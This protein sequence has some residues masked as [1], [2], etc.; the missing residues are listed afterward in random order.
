MSGKLPHF[1][2]AAPGIT[3]QGCLPR[4]KKQQVHER[5]GEE[6]MWT[7]GTDV[8]QLTKGHDYKPLHTCTP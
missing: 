2:H 8:L 5:W 6:D 7:G 1:I 4:E 3:T